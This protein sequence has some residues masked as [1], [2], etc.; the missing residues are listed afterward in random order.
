[1]DIDKNYG[2]STHPREWSTQELYDYAIQHELI[3][4]YSTVE[5][6]MNNKMDLVRVIVTESIKTHE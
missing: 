4:Q 3:D 1:M 5:D 2:F 6:W